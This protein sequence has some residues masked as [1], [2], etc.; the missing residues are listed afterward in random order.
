[1]LTEAD[2]RK[3]GKDDFTAGLNQLGQDGWEL[4]SFNPARFI[5]KRTQSLS[6]GK[7]W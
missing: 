5:L 1:V 3:L 2:I 4:V 6:F 7:D